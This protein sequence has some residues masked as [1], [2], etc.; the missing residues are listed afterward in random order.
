[1]ITPA[2]QDLAGGAHDLTMI[3]ARTPARTQKVE[4]A[5]RPLRWALI[6]GVGVLLLAILAALFLFSRRPARALAP[7]ETAGTA[8]RGPVST[9][10]GFLMVLS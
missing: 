7:H 4:A 10:Y 9:P 1:M 8:V 3:H 6:L 2:A 5:A